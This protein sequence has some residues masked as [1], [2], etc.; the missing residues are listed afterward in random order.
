MVNRNKQIIN[1][2]FLYHSSDKRSNS[3]ASTASEKFKQ[4]WC[5]LWHHQRCMNHSNHKKTARYLLNMIAIV[6]LKFHNI[7]IVIFPLNEYCFK[8]R[9]LAGGQATTNCVCTLCSRLITHLLGPSIAYQ[10][11]TI[12]I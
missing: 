2:C 12:G 8:G 10:E 11:S 1:C 4:T 6:F 9:V 3:P 5:R 7:F